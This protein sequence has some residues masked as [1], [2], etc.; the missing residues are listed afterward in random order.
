MKKLIPIASIAALTLSHS[1]QALDTVFDFAVTADLIWEYDE[2]GFDAFQDPW[3]E[4]IFGNPYNDRSDFLAQNAVFD[5]V[6]GDTFVSG[7]ALLTY[8]VLGLTVDPSFDV[9]EVYDWNITGLV[10]YSY[11]LQ[12]TGQ[13][14]DSDW[15]TLGDSFAFT[16]SVS[17]I[18]GLLFG[19]TP[20]Q[21]ATAFL[22]LP[23]SGSVSSLFADINLL[24]GLSLPTNSSL[25][26]NADFGLP[27]GSIQVIA[28]QPIAGI[29]YAAGDAFGGLFIQAT[30]PVPDVSSTGLLALA[31]FGALVAARRRFRD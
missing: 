2:F 16:A 5:Q 7:F 9:N 17:D 13:P 3:G 15:G 29:E 28:P 24:T 20:S 14:L 25:L 1:A 22:S 27:T 19:A 23:G 26:Y 4:D 8:E 18:T 21:V 30:R 31:G 6:Q 11:D 12:E 10:D